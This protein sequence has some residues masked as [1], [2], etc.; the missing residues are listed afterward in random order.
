MIPKLCLHFTIFFVN[1]AFLK[2]EM[3][4]H[5][6]GFKEPLATIDKVSCSPW[7]IVA[8]RLTENKI[9]IYYYIETG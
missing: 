4:K 9:M 1:L 5:S 3:G 8:G 7:A 6:C 2:T